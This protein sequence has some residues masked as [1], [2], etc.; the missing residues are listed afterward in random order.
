[1][2]EKIILFIISFC[3]IS[4]NVFAVPAAPNGALMKGTVV[5][6]SI[7]SSAARSGKQ[8]GAGLYKIVVTVE[9]TEDIPDVSNFLADKKGQDIE[10]WSKERLDPSLFQK[11][12]RATVEYRGDERGGKFW[13]RNIEL[14]NNN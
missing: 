6:Y 10:C 7:T 4:F 2:T 9:S 8:P 13:I 1:M 5:E 11:K 14:R 12:I 3:I